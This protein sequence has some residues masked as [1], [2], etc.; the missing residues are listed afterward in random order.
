MLVYS[1]GLEAC[2]AYVRPLA[3]V[4]ARVYCQGRSLNKLSATVS[5][6]AKAEYTVE[7]LKEIP[8]GSDACQVKGNPDLLGSHTLT[9]YF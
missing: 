4:N 5:Y 9:S 1:Q 2:I 8:C 6:W 3:S 7:F